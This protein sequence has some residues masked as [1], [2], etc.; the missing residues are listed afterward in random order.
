M[1][2]RRDAGGSRARRSR[3]GR[4]RARTARELLVAPDLDQQHAPAAAGRRDRQGGGHGRLPGAPLA[5]HDHEPALE[6][7][8]RAAAVSRGLRA[9]GAA[10]AAPPALKRSVGGSETSFTAGAAGRSRRDPSTGRPRGRGGRAPL[11]VTCE[12]CATQFQLD[13]A[14]GSGG[15]RS[16]ALLA[17]QARL[18]HRAGGGAPELGTHRSRR[19]GGAGS[20]MRRPRPSRPRTWPPPRRP[21]SDFGGR[22][23]DLAERERL[24]VQRGPLRRAKRPRRADAARRAGRR[25]RGDRRPARRARPRVAARRRSRSA[26]E[27]LAP[28]SAPGAAATA[29]TPRT[30]TRKPRELGSARGRRAGLP[31]GGRRSRRAPARSAVASAAAAHGGAAAVARPSGSN[32]RALGPARLD[33]AQRTRDRV[34]RDRDAVA[35]S[36]PSPRSAPASAPDAEPQF[37]RQQLAQLEAQGIAGRWVENAAAGPLFVVSGGS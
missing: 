3:R 2:M 5:G 25:A 19:A 18:L 22:R 14:E 15:R 1:R 34:E 6:Q 31:T 20:S 24:G 12:Q 13:D 17:L 16:R 35:R 33:R 36:W 23:N 32:P 7:R 28:G 11:I 37:G 10:A 4:R 29:P 21:A 26:S 27:S 8:G 9:Q 30:R